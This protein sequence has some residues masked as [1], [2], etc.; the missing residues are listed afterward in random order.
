MLP[1]EITVLGEDDKEI[2]DFLE[3]VRLANGVRVQVGSD[4]LIVKVSNEKITQS[5]RDYL[6]KGGRIAE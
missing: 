3:K 2:I 6:T 5:G 1:K 4:V